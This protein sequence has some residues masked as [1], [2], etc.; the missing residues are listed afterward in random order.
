MNILI[1]P[2]PQES[3]SK[4]ACTYDHFS[5]LQQDIGL[6]IFEAIPEKLYPYILDIGMGTGWLT[7]KIAKKFPESK[8]VGLDYALG[9]V[10]KEK[11]RNIHF[12]LQADARKLPFKK[13]KFDLVVSNC[14][15]QWVQDIPGAFCE[16]ARVLKPRGEF[17][18]TCFGASTL[19][20]LREA[21]SKNVQGKPS[22]LHHWHLLEKEKIRQALASAGFKDVKVASQ[23][24]TEYFK[25]LFDLL[26]W[27]KLIGANGAKRNI[28]VGRQLLAR[29]SRYYEDHF[30]SCDGI[31]ATFEIIFGTAR[32]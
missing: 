7:E 2:K 1:A 28:F 4:A 24:R 22:E 14:A 18:F 11:K 30:R 5:A 29:A 19:K 25:D 21:L 9:M 12:V 26:S 15:Y 17:Y 16:N 10:K 23:E 13:E 20:E 27:L 6:K 8:M 31:G 3:F 32:K